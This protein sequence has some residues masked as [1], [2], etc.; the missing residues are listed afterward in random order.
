M[1]IPP[2]IGNPYNGYINPYYW[3]DDHPLLYG[4]NGSLD[5]STYDLTDARFQQELEDQ[6]VEDVHIALKVYE[7]HK[8]PT[9]GGK[10]IKSDTYK[11]PKNCIHCV[12]CMQ[13]QLIQYISTFIIH[14]ADSNRVCS[15]GMNCG[16]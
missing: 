13:L 4:N 14:P 12:Y 10:H 3:V 1:V 2:L 7:M 6:A 9:G 15:L 8:E 11:P 5:P 16:S